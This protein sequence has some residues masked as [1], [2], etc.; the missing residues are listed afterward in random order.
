M[1]KCKAIKLVV[2]SLYKKVAPTAAFIAQPCMQ[3]LTDTF[4]PYE[5][6]VAVSC[7]SSAILLVVFV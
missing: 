7:L 3:A 6:T 5:V 2:H 4:Q 1:R